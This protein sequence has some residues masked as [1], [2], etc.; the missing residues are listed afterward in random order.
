MALRVPLPDNTNP[1]TDITCQH[2]TFT[3]IPSQPSSHMPQR[4][5]T[6]TPLT[7]ED[8][9]QTLPSWTAQ[10]FEGYALLDDAHKVIHIMT[11][12]PQLYFT[13]DG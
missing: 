9:V 1:V 2:H 12:S 8:Y 4:A 3:C 7:F 6:P 10:L 13:T 11:T 5:S